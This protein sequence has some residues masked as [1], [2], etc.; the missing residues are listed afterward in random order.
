MSGRAAATSP[1]WLAAVRPTLALGYLSLSHL[2]TA[3]ESPR[4]A[5]LAVGLIVLLLL[6]EPL[7]H[8]RAWAFAVTALA[9][10]ALWLLKDSAHI[11]IALLLMPVFFLLLLAWL[12]GRTLQPGRTPVIGKIV[13]ALEGD[14]YGDVAPE[15]D[16]YTRGLTALWTGVFIILALINL[17]LALIATPGGLLARAGID[18]AWSISDS[19]WSWFANWLNYGLVGGVFVIEFAYRKHRFP[20]RYKNAVDFFR[21]MA[22]LGPAFWRDLFK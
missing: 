4:L 22:G 19:Q 3:R 13:R 5:A 15:L 12:F 1:A 17:T 16:R 20:G 11:H 6:A 10:A 8:R 14:A 7:W 18:A 21:R 9:A 2:A